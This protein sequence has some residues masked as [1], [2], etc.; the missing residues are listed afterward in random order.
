MKI[1]IDMQGIQIG[2]TRKRGIS[3]YSESLVTALCHATEN[4]VAASHPYPDSLHLLWS[5]LLPEGLGDLQATFGR[6]LPP[7]RMHLWHGA[8]SVVQL[9]PAD[10]WL[11]QANELMREAVI[12]RLQPDI[13][14]ITSH[15]EGLLDQA[16]SSIHALDQARPV[17]SIFYDLIPYLYREQY[18]IAP[19]AWRWYQRRM[20]QA[21]SIDLLATISESSRQEAIN[22][23]GLA[24]ERVV[25]I[26]A[27]A[28]PLFAPH[29]LTPEQEHEVRSRLALP[30]AFLLYV[31]AT[32]ERKNH[33]RLIEAYAGLPES[34][35]RDCPLVLVGPIA[36]GQQRV[37]RHHAHRLGMA[38]DQLRLLS[39]L[40]DADLVL[41]YQLCT[42][43]V[44]ASWH[45]GF[46]LPILEAMRCGAPVLGADAS[47][48]KELIQLPAALFNPWDV[49]AIRARLHQV[50][51]DPDFRQELRANGARRAACYSWSHSAQRLLEALRDTHRRWQR[52]HPKPTVVTPTLAALE[53]H[54]LDAIAA[55]PGQPNRRDLAAIVQ[56]IEQNFR[57]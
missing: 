20:Q 25:A 28:D 44:F 37:F 41:V 34:L 36:S 30:G 27:D 46:G 23:L 2:V 56:A 42:A 13:V 39:G 57:H 9:F 15:F 6:Y 55:L 31:S 24:P 5:D 45:E 49:T 32:D 11:W 16:V 38:S 10:A 22:G 19:T 12:A 17:C 43:M 40:P 14:L 26:D 35:R 54:L 8:P 7:E 51:T 33:W 48:T 4:A 53:E 47:S 50:I 1:L 52:D 3:R 21:A 29:T 18:L